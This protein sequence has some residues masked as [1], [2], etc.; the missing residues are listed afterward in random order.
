[1]DAQWRLDPKTAPAFGAEMDRRGAL[2]LECPF[3]PQD[4]AHHAALAARIRT[5]LAIGESYRTHF[6]MAPFFRA[7]AM[8]IVQPDLGRC[9]IT[10][11]LRI[12]RAAERAGMEVVPH[13]AP[14]LGPLLFATLQFA[15]ATPNCRMVPHRPGLLETAGEYSTSPVEFRNGHYTV[16]TAPGLGVDVAE[17][18]VRLVEVA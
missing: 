15:A 16:P 14:A 6:E 12:A 1:V 11:A 17:P 3:L 2:W 18:E 10:E 13:L 7:G 5:P 4:V 8:R 9:G